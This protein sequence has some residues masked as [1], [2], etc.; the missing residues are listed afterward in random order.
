MPRKTIALEENL[1]DRGT[2]RSAP[3]SASA[4]PHR[5]DQSN[6]RL[7]PLASEDD[8]NDQ[9]VSPPCTCDHTLARK[10]IMYGYE[11]LQITFCASEPPCLIRPFESDLPL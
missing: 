5:R 11:A 3:L 4:L 1:P 8:P 7:Q 6:L 10:V 9:E 2:A